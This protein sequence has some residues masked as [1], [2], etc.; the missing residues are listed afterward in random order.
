[1]KSEEREHFSKIGG[2]FMGELTFR[3]IPRYEENAHPNAS[4]GASFHVARFVA[5]NGAERGIEPK[6]RDRLQ[7]HSRV[8]FA[9]RV[10]ATVLPNAVH[11]VIGAVIHAADDGALLRKSV[12]HPLRQLRIGFFVELAAADTGLVRD[13]NDGPLHLIGPEAAKL[14]YAG[15][16]LE[17]IGP[18]DVSPINIDDAIPVEEERALRHGPSPYVR[19]HI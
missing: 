10:I 11:R 4:C 18:M 17:L 12:A 1:M 5:D 6:I 13:D 9:P 19:R 2:S 16:E 15:N 8:G 7:E 14:E 3:A